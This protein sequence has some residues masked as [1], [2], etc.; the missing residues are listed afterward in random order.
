MINRIATLLPFIPLLLFISCCLLLFFQVTAYA[1]KLPGGVTSRLE[2]IDQYMS[3]VEQASERNR[4]DR[5][6]L[7]CAQSTLNEI[8]TQYPANA[9]ADEVRSAEERINKGV[10]AIEKLEKAQADEKEKTVNKEKSAETIAEEWADKLAP[11]KAESKEGSKGNYGEPMSEATRIF[12]LASQ[13]QEAKKVYEEFLATG[14]DKDSHWKLREA[15]YN[16][17]VALDNYES[18]SKRAIEEG[19]KQVKEAREWQTKQKPLPEPILLLADRMTALREAVAGVRLLLPAKSAQL[20]EINTD[21][22]ELEKVFVEVEV[23]V[24]KKRMMKPDLYKGADL[25]TVKSLATSIVLKAEAKS[26]ILRTHV[27]NAGWTTESVKE[28][29][30]T[31]KTA[32]QLRVTKGINVQVALTIND[33]CFLYTLFIN[34]DTIGGVKRPLTG[35]IMYKDKF[36][37]QNLPK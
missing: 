20:K 3:K 30:D 27:I 4:V 36:L 15:E 10:A 22:A 35:H 12:A 18:S 28:W 24:L 16:I 14:I 5:N 1:E 11:Y 17:K 29:T 33:G 19:A 37:Q 23:V 9:K 26:K 6:N 8:K 31:T 25:A 2:K 13:Y 32:E 21:L 7:E 34:Q